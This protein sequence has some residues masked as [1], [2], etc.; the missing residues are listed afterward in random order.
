MEEHD[1][2]DPAQLTNEKKEATCDRVR[3]ENPG[4]CRP[5]PGHIGEAYDEQTP[6]EFSVSQVC[7]TRCGPGQKV[8]QLIGRVAGH[9][10]VPAHQEGQPPVST[11]LQRPL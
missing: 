7:S 6:R 10:S 1:D 8:S 11:D 5:R 3:D 2:E 4:L 9:P